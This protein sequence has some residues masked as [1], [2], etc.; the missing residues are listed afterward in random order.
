MPQTLGEDGSKAAA[1]DF[2]RTKQFVPTRTHPALP[3]V[4][5]YETLAGFLLMPVD[6]LRDMFLSW[7]SKEEKHAAGK[8]YEAQ[9]GRDGL[10]I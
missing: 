2:S 1:A 5:P 4:P 7:P 8:A 3:N 10:G 6:K 9:G